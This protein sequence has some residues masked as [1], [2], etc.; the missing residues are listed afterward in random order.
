MHL[1]SIL[2]LVTHR[3]MMSAYLMCCRYEA[4]LLQMGQ[5]AEEDRK[6]VTHYCGPLKEEATRTKTPTHQLALYSSVTFSYK[7]T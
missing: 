7:L 6:V 1:S 4:P 5:T 2:K 3:V